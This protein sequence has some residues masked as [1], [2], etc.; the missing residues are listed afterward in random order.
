MK[1]KWNNLGWK[2]V[3]NFTNKFKN[4]VF[5]YE[6]EEKVTLNIW[7][8][9]WFERIRKEN[10]LIINETIILENQCRAFRFRWHVIFGDAQISRTVQ[11][12]NVH[13]PWCPIAVS[14]SVAPNS[15]VT[16]IMNLK[17]C[18]SYVNSMMTDVFKNTLIFND[19]TEYYTIH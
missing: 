9:W 15:T 1:R 5:A 4:I 3:E 8:F 10:E 12:Q 16:F 6:I 17:Y 19:D 7:L 14:L 18:F 2:M 13:V 11:I